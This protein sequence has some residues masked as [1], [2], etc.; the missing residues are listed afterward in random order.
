MG[1]PCGLATSVWPLLAH[2]SVHPCC[3]DQTVQGPS[4]HHKQGSPGSHM[5]YYPSLCCD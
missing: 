3:G 4:F 2:C 5:S 1:S